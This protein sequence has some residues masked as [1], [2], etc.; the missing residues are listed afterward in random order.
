[1]ALARGLTHPGL[2]E[3][4]DPDRRDPSG[5]RLDGHRVPEERR[6]WIGNPHV[7]VDV[8]LTLDR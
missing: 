2:D 1:M 5:G 3:E 8:L 4:D 6:G 7:G